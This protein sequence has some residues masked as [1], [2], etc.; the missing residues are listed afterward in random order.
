[1]SVLSNTSAFYL[2]VCVCVYFSDVSCLWP[3]LH[4]EEEKHFC[5]Q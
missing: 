5:G 2:F 1:M 3:G 4:I